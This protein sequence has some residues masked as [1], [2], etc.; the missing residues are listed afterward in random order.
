MEEVKEKIKNIP[1]ILRHGT[2]EDIRDLISV[3]IDH[4]SIDGQDLTICWKF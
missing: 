2:Y 4:I 1:D 3:L